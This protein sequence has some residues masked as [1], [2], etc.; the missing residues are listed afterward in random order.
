LHRVAT[1]RRNAALGHKPRFIACHWQ[2][3]HSAAEV[4]DSCSS[5]VRSPFAVPV[6]AAA[7]P[8]QVTIRSFAGPGL[9]RCPSCRFRFN[10]IVDGS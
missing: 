3:I 7:L 10:A 5:G 1:H 6:L 2:W 8:V 9:E 4:D